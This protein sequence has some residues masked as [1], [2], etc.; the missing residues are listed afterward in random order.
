MLSFRAAPGLGLL[1]QKDGGC[2]RAT[3]TLEHRG[4]SGDR[5]GVLSG[6]SVGGSSSGNA[7][8]LATGQADLAVGTD[9][10]GSIRVPP[11]FC[12]VVGLKPTHGLVPYTGITPLDPAIDHAGVMSTTVADTALLLS[13]VA[14]YDDYDLGN[15]E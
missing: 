6:Y 1:D 2:S 3:A 9:Q 10:A 8:T 13:V 11:S 12:G 15:D 4:P 7:V 5:P 14:G